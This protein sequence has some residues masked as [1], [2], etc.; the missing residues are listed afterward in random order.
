LFKKSLWIIILSFV[1]EK[2]LFGGIFFNTSKSI[3]FS[4]SKIILPNGV[5]FTLAS[6]V[7]SEKAKT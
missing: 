1:S 6:E 3:D 4:I 2:R 5:A 7:R